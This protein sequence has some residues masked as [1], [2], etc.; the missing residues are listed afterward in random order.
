MKKKK[1]LS[2]ELVIFSKSGKPIFTRQINLKRDEL[3]ASAPKN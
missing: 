1:E 3:V 2:T